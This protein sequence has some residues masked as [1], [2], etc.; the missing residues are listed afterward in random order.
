MTY[1]NVYTPFRLPA[2]GAIALLVVV[3]ISSVAQAGN[4]AT[5]ARALNDGLGPDAGTWR[6][7]ASISV[8][9]IPFLG[10]EVSA[11][12]DWAAFAPG[13]FQL[14]LDD[15]G[16]AESD[17]SGV[18]EVVYAY[19]I[20]SVTA[21]SPG[22]TTLT[23]GVDSTDGRGSVLPP[24]FVPAGGGSEVDPVGGGDQ[25]TSMAW[26][27][28]G[29]ALQVGDTTGLLVFSS[30]FAPELDSMQ[31]SSGLASPSPSPLVASISDRIYDNNIP[32]P[33]SIA[34]LLIGTLGLAGGRRK[35]FA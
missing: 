8:A 13:D 29:S 17:P 20:V 28:D 31:I 26:F 24:A 30:P 16:I 11:L 1:C 25:T 10:D 9:P 19:Q 7:Q 22:I 6:G 2:L 33:S 5:T 14:Y 23:V 35:R 21:A 32:E 27:F 34:L 4:L 18:L 15:E 12:V 3:S